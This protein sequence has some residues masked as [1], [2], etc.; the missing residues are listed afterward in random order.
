MESILRGMKNGYRCSMINKRNLIR[1]IRNPALVFTMMRRLF[2]WTAILQDPECAHM[3]DAWSSGKLV[4]V[5]INEIF[6]GVENCNVVLRNAESRV[7]GWSLDLQELVHL[8][9][10]VRLTK[11]NHILEIGTYDAFQYNL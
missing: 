6:A 7:V 1:A 2:P 10:V 3:I 9:S 4:R 8:L 11:P 5:A